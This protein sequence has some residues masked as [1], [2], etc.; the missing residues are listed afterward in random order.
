MAR[1]SSRLERKQMIRFRHINTAASMVERDLAAVCVQRSPPPLV[2]RQ[3]ASLD[4][5]CLCNHELMEK[6]LRSP[7]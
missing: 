1:V 7:S 6:E 2:K 3:V 5:A 4:I